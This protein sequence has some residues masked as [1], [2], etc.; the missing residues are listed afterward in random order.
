MN[1]LVKRLRET[2]K[3]GE[4]YTAPR[5]QLEAA[6]RIEELEKE[7]NKTEEFLRAVLNKAK[8][9]AELNNDNQTN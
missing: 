4:Y 1:D 7:L 2:G 8:K 9:I 5:I 3:L 6:K